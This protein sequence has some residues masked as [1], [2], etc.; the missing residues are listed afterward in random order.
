MPDLFS[1]EPQAYAYGVFDT[2]TNGLPR[3]GQ[4][5]R[6]AA[7]SL[8]R[9][10]PTLSV[11]S[12]QLVYIKRDGWRM[13]EGATAVNGITDAFLDQHGVPVAEALDMYEAAIRSDRVMVG[14]NIRFDVRVLRAEME[15]AGRDPLIERTLTLCMQKKLVG[16]C[17]LSY[18][19]ESNRKGVKPP[20][21]SEALA[22][23]K[24]PQ[25]GAH[26]AAGDSF[27]ALELLK[28]A[29]RIGL[30]LEPEVILDNK[31]KRPKSPLQPYDQA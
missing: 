31:T 4:Q 10:S 8:I 27:G 26:T 2:E 16:V 29:T 24:I 3:D 11:Q 19:P 20:K 30:T 17:R 14:F 13:E 15:R 21:L 12:E 18:P 9:T 1:R 6:L 22:H 28:A 25:M 5:P 7:F 23:F